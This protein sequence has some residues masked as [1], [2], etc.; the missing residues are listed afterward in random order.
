VQ[1]KITKKINSELFFMVALIKAKC[2]EVEDFF[3]L[4]SALI[5]VQ[6]TIYLIACFT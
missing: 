3:N 6:I 2:A 5:A 1:K 4:N